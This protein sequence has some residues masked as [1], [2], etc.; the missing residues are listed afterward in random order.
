MK[1]AFLI[2]LLLHGIIHMLGFVKSYHLAE[3]PQLPLNIPKSLGNLWLFSSILLLAVFILMIFNK[4]WWPFFA[5]AA[6]ILSQTLI[7]LYWPDAKY[8]T[9]LNM[10]ILLVSIPATGKY[11]FDSVV[12]KEAKELLSNIPLKT[13]G[14]INKD[15]LGHLPKIVQKWMDADKILVLSTLK[16]H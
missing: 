12:Q 15:D 3:V 9:I 5:I 7:F 13:V 14:K 1:T 4:T 8:G 6:V 2:T 11:Q 16:A 10:I